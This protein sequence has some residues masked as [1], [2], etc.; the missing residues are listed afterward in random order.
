MISTAGSPRSIALF[1]HRGARGLRPENTIEGFAAIAALGLTGA[2]FDV[3]LT[4]DDVAVVHHDAR[5]NPDIARDPSGAWLALEVAPLLRE[6]R[7]AE[8]ATFDVGR[9]RPGTAYEAR[10][11]VQA[12]ADGARIPTL[13]AVIEA[14]PGRDLLVEIKTFPDHPDL[15]APPA[16]MA[17]AM[18]DALRRHG[19]I[20]R[21][22]LFAFDWRVLREAAAI[23][24]GLRRCCLTAPDTL[25]AASLWLD[26]TDLEAFGGHL[27][28]AVAATGA[29]CWAPFHGTL[30][31]DEV[32]EAHA[33]GLLVLPW[34]VN[35]A[36]A[37]D[38]MIGLGVDGM[39]SDR[40]DLARNAILRAGS[41]V[42]APGFVAAA[43]S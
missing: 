34:T 17:A 7:F 1:G 10:Y 36:D 30:Q 8:L 13:D 16:R 3:G 5:L 31:Q 24:P 33:L 22:L 25:E 29:V 18:I 38:R 35:T 42:A 15:T 11:P 9:L 19:A 20:D 4:A 26:G 2:E 28:R 23:E 21:A 32:R 6:R 40:P 37:F 41:Q 27:P 43:R 12:P 39:I 14:L